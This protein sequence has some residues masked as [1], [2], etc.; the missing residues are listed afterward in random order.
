MQHQAQVY[1]QAGRGLSASTESTHKYSKLYFNVFGHSKAFDSFDEMLENDNGDILCN[2][3]M[4]REFA[5]WLHSYGRQISNQNRYIDKGAALNYL[6]SLTTLCARKWPTHPTWQ[7]SSFDTWY[8]EIRKDIENV[9][10]RR[11]I[12][13]GDDNGEELQ[14]IDRALLIRLVERWNDIG[15]QDALLKVCAATMTYVGLGRAGEFAFL[16]GTTLLTQKLFSLSLAT[17]TS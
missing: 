7:K 4:W 14:D 5:T 1:A 6:S 3:A 15:T 16:T 8:Q 12:E 2:V 17:I 9:I 10:G 13:D 11:E